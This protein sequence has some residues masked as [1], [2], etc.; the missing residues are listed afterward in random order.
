MLAK[1]LADSRVSSSHSQRN[2]FMLKPGSLRAA[3]LRP[4]LI[5]AAG[6]AAVL[7]C[8]LHWL[9]PSEPVPK[10]FVFNPGSSWITTNSTV[11][12]TGCFRLNLFVPRKIEK[13]WIAFGTNGGYHLY[14]NGQTMA[15]APPRR[16]TR[17]FQTTLSEGGQRL[18]PED[19]TIWANYP[20][21]YQ[22]SDHD[23]A[24]LPVWLDLTS[25]LHPGLN[26]ISIEVDSEGTFPNPAFIMSGEV[27][28][29]SGETVPISSDSTWF[30][31]PVPKR[32]PQYGWTDPKNP[33]FDWA[34]AKVLPIRR[35]YWRLFAPEIF[36]HPFEGSTIYCPKTKEITWIEK[37]FDLPGKPDESFIRVLSNSVYHVWINNQPISGVTRTTSV[38]GYGP[39]FFRELGMLPEDVSLNSSPQWLD[40]NSVA[41]LLPGQQ[42][43]TPGQPDPAVNDPAPDQS[44][45]A[46]TSAYPFGQDFTAD[47]ANKGLRG[48][49]PS[50]NLANPEQEVSPAL[51]SNPRR[52][53]FDAYYVDPLLHRG[54]N[55]IRIALY[56]GSLTA[57]DLSN[58]DRF[59]AVD[60][61]SRLAN[62]QIYT[63]RSDDTWRASE[64]SFQKRVAQRVIV[65]AKLSPGLMPTMKFFGYINPYRPWFAVTLLFFIIIFPI[66]IFLP[67]SSGVLGDWTRF[68][69]PCACLV[70]WTFAAVIL[71]AAM[72]ERSE[73]LYWRFPQAWLCMLSLGLVGAA[74]AYLLPNRSRERRNSD[75]K[76]AIAKKEMSWRSPLVLAT[77]VLC[78]ALRT[79]QMDL[80]P[81]D[82]DEYVSIQASLAV[83][84]LGVPQFQPGVWYTRSPA[85]HYLA[86]AVAFLTGS[87]IYT[88]RLLSA[89]FSCLT[90]LLV[91]QMAK[92]LTGDRLLAFCALIFITIHPFEII[93]GHVARFYQMQQY[94][95]LLTY[96]V[97]LRGFVGNTGMRDR[98]LT[99]LLFLI[100]VLSQ[101][102]S[103][104]ALPPLCI[105]YI[106]FGQRRS[107][108]DEVRIA[109]AAGCAVA[110]IALDVA[111][112][113]I[114]CMT[115]LDGLSPSLDSAVG[116]YF[117][118]SE[119]YFTM[120][121]GYSRLH[122]VLTAFLVPGFIMAWRQRKTLW[123]CT[124][125][126]FLLNILF[127]NL[128]ITSS[129]YRFQYSIIPIWLLLCVHG[130][131]EMAKLLIG[132]REDRRLRM[133]MV[134]GWVAIAL[135]SWSPW[136]ISKS[137][138]T[139]LQGDDTRALRYVSQN[140][141]PEDRIAI[142]ELYPQ[143]S[144]IEAGR[145]D[146]DLSVPILYDFAVRKKG[147]LVDRNGAAKLLG[148]L[149]ALQ[150]A[151]AQND[152][153]WVIYDE[154]QMH[155]EGMDVLWGY[156]AG[157]VNLFLQNNAR[158]V[159]RSHLWDVYLWDRNA[160]IYSTFKE[161]PNDW[162]E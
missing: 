41:T 130:M 122:L 7:Y 132:N 152:R 12:A 63:F 151:F 104:L 89:V 51:T 140:L 94:F 77:L 53:E 83:G 52:V 128:F 103:I 71:R 43:E 147:I 59:V 66:L 115:A 16:R 15:G 157:R 60:G 23:G 56:N 58:I 78:F 92:K 145:V 1:Q 34:R 124:Y 97:F 101:E 33:V 10:P 159:F 65:G 153:L 17:S 121:I 40:P 70:A 21:E 113:Q 118:R 126:Y 57:S 76:P 25:S 26:A 2:R 13:A 6:L 27:R 62:G 54:R 107:W 105:C 138:Y 120:L 98:Y 90:A 129:G 35:Q 142:C 73:A 100:S 144:L 37:D 143:A 116:W 150:R 134:V 111:F 137:Y 69:L 93:T 162:F 114:E 19:A 48:Q 82:E 155:A 22:W 32:V 136:R 95:S 5:V 20:R 135:V 141:R 84:K 127:T 18:S 160:G 112:F 146:Y 80:Q 29:Q 31:E 9:L 74:L 39:W 99:V 87:N 28:L 81:P 67:K 108:P 3:S 44:R 8:I 109:V 30:A 158:L 4:A 119:N 86:G 123:C 38:L 139:T 61:G 36:Q 156:A 85:Y 133:A 106:L 24:E 148:N 49:S 50:A 45:S 161:Q 117:E 110:L 72:L 11:Q 46:G 125:V 91:W 68:E 154:D 75:A 102:I 96:A 14:V 64:G 149:S 79:Y 88:L 42:P 131:G 55:T 47:P